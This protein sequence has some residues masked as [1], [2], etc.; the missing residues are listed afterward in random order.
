MPYACYDRRVA[1]VGI[2]A[3]LLAALVAL[4]ALVT[5]LPW[6][7]TFG[8]GIA[9]VAAGMAIGVPAGALYHVRLYR[10]V[11]PRGAWWLRPT[12]LHPQLPDGARPRVMSAF[13]LGA[14]GFVLAIA[15]CALVALGAVRSALS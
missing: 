8:I 5:W 13:K 4:P 14:F 7:M 12:A 3:A 9:L 6:E 15:G 2:A 11:K 1:E 10:L